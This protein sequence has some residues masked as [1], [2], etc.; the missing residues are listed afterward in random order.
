MLIPQ[1]T[2]GKGARKQGGDRADLAELRRQLANPSAASEGCRQRLS[3]LAGHLAQ[4]RSLGDEFSRV[5]F[6]AAAVA[7]MD[8]GVGGKRA[9]PTAVGAAEQAPAALA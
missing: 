5:D 3:E 8:Y 6:S 2:A 4:L 7:V 1:G 9:N